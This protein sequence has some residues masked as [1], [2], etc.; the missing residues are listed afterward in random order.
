VTPRKQYPLES[1]LQHRK[2]RVD[3]QSLELADKIRASELAARQRAR[4]QAERESHAEEVQASG[5]AEEVLLEG[6]ALCAGDLQ[7]RQA[8]EHA[9]AGVA[10]TLEQQE[11]GAKA[12]E[13]EARRSELQSRTEALRACADAEVLVR[14]RDT[15]VRAADRREQDA[16]EE[17]AL[18]AHN[19]RRRQGGA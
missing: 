3:E 2:Q 4:A 13:Q 16:A 8:W 15:F 1:V 10:Q 18:E 5:A 19:A 7:Q 14:H 12:H 17:D 9:Q 6:G 11:D